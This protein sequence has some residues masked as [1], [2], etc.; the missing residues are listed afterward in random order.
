MT[1]IDSE[2]FPLFPFPSL[3]LPTSLPFPLSLSSLL[4]RVRD[5]SHNTHPRTHQA[6]D[7]L[8]LVADPSMRSGRKANYLRRLLSKG[9]G[10]G[11]PH[12]YCDWDAVEVRCNACIVMHKVRSTP[13]IPYMEK[14]LCTDMRLTYR[15]RSSERSHL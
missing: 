14:I 9:K 10:C 7:V 4:I 13:S 3:Q 15:Y 12:Y 6:D 2:S 1:I 11:F 5:R 8:W